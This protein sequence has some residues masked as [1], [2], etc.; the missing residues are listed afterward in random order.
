METVTFPDAQVSAYANETFVPVLVDISQDEQTAARYGISGI[1]A[2][3]VTTPE[4][5]TVDEQVGF[6]DPDG[7][8]EWMRRAHGEVQQNKK[9]GSDAGRSREGS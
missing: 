4:G 3:L 5:E 8:L 6:V 9:Q 2:T 1:P 7:Y